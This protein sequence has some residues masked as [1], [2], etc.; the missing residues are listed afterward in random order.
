[1]SLKRLSVEKNTGYQFFR[2]PPLLII[3]TFSL[4]QKG[5][6]YYEKCAYY[7]FAYYE[8]ARFIIIFIM[9]EIMLS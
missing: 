4:G 2:N 5:C 8:W 3:S 7:E 9:V 6:A 1:M